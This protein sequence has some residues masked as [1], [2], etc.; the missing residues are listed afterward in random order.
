MKVHHRKKRLRKNYAR[1]R[2][3]W[4]NRAAASE[5]AFRVEQL[6]KVKLAQKFDPKKYMDESLGELH[7]ELT[8]GTFKGKRLPAWLIKE[9]VKK[10]VVEEERVKRMKVDL[11]T[12]EPLVKDRET[13]EEFVQRMEESRRQK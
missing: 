3:T 13:V 8:P 2:K 1:F 9:L 10:E 5:V 4:Q 6:G 11:I 12:K 7:Q